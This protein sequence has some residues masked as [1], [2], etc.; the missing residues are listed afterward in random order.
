MVSIGK[1]EKVEL[2]TVWENEASDF[3]PWLLQNAEY[4]SEVLN[5]DLELSASE[6]GV[7]PY[8]VDLIGRDASNDCVVII[9][10]QLEKTD[11]R[12]LG[13]LITYAATTDAVVIVWIAK[14][15]TDEHRQAIDFLNSL[16][17]ESNKGRF[18]GIEVSAVRIGNSLPAAQFEVVARPND[19]HTSQVEAVRDLI[20]PTGRRLMY[21]NFWKMYL[22]KVELNSPGLTN[23][24][25][26]WNSSWFDVTKRL[27]GL[28]HISLVF[29]NKSRVNVQLYIS[30]GDAEENREAFRYLHSHKE[31][32]EREI[33]IELWWESSDG[34]RFCRIA[35]F[36]PGD[37]DISM[38]DQYDD[39]ATWMLEMNKRFKTVFIP[40]L[41]QYANLAKSD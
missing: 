20:E 39:I 21:R 16:S 29:N 38:T 11:H 8:S 19:A 28:A 35:A 14:K 41:D 6:H 4:L 27:N 24:S 18:Y 15:F 7:G 3:T 10:N 12:H 31:E 26:P 17:N 1:L 2:R 9:E 36:M 40:F 33:G 22:E 5:M 32:I 25:A 30:G 13:Q 34:K 37:R 23:R